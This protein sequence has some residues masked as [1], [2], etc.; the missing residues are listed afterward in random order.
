[1]KPFYTF[2]IFTLLIKIFVSYWVPMS[3]DEAYYWIW[4]L[5][6]QLS[7][8]DHP[9]LIS[10]ILSIGNVLRDIH[11]FLIRFPGILLGHLTLLVWLEIFRFLL[12]KTNNNQHIFEKTQFRSFLWL[13][14]LSPL[15]GLGSIIQTPDLPLVFFWSLSIFWL[16]KY[17]SIPSLATAMLLGATLGIGFL[18]KYHMVLFIPPLILWLLVERK[19]SVIRPQ[20]L[21]A[22]ILVGLV[23]CL[24]VVLWNV[25]ND[26][27]SFKFQLNHGLS[28]PDYKFEWTWSYLLGQLFLLSPLVA[29]AVF[30]SKLDGVARALYYF[31]FFPIVFFFGT[32]FFALVEANWPIAAFPSLLAIAALSNIR[33]IH[34]W[35]TSG[36]WL[37]IY[38]ILFVAVMFFS[39]KVDVSKFT[40]ES[41]IRKWEPQIKIYEPLFFDTYQNASLYSWVK[42]APYCKLSG[43]GRLDYFDFVGECK[44]KES[45][46]YFFANLDTNPPEWVTEEGK[47][48][49]RVVDTVDAKFK[50]Y[51]IERLP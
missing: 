24:P 3:A 18:A 21:F 19:W 47:Y 35:I 46:F 48:T 25:Q 11:P 27:V 31:G 33:Q 36:F 34:V 12:P 7:Y 5:N 42:Q 6:P 17:I 8:Y 16:I 49:F 40:E 43:V 2:W 10:W 26:F 39:H 14:L 29:Y 4:S 41:F 23:F 15:L 22:A 44:P 1:M 30:K 37:S 32:S 9:P 50:I 28:R 45:V 13:V 51:R 20:H 38:S